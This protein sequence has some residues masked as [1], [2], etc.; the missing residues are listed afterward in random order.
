MAAF[1][2]LPMYDFDFES[3]RQAHDTWYRC[4]RNEALRLGVDERFLPLA[5]EPSDS[6]S[7]DEM[8]T[9]DAAKMT[10]AQTCGLPLISGYRR[11][12]QLLGTPV[13]NAEGC[14]STNYSSIVVAS[15]NTQGVLPSDFEGMTAA[16][17]SSGTCAS[18]PPY[19]LTYTVFTTTVVSP[20][21]NLPTFFQGPYLERCS[22]P[23]G[24][25]PL[26]HTYEPSPPAVT[27]SP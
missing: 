2:A 10:L 15:S 8:L 13:Y 3:L 23:L 27:P 1:A 6:R 21:L 9:F 4:I 20:S 5:L 17:N 18:T 19:Q 12:L 11:S 7:M 22:C 26:L 16:V 24:S 14:N 25:G